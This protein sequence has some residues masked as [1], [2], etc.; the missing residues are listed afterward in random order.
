MHVDRELA[1]LAHLWQVWGEVG[2]GLDA[3]AWERP[4][5]CAVWDVRALYAHVSQGVAGLEALVTK[6][7]ADGAVEHPDAVALLRALKPTA[8]AAAELATVNADRAVDD[9]RATST[10]RLVARFTAA[11][12]RAIEQAAP[13]LETT[14]DYFRRGRVP[15]RAAV[16]IRLV[17]STVHLLDLGAALDRD[18]NLSEEALARTAQFLLAMT[19]VVEFIEAATG[20]RQPD[21]FPVHS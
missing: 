10:D 21:M 20:R 4:T 15:L 2:E 7:R 5:R 18:L 3:V 6:R 19:P 11:G 8:G 13:C 1:T 14:V 12:P 9:A 17:E 16:T